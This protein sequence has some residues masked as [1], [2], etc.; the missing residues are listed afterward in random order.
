MQPAPALTTC[1]VNGLVGCFLITCTLSLLFYSPLRFHASVLGWPGTPVLHTLDLGGPRI[2]A[3]EKRETTD[4]STPS[5]LICV[6]ATLLLP[7]NARPRRAHD[8]AKIATSFFPQAS[9][10]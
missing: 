6:T 2:L 1:R 5:Q 7:R 9:R 4:S 10:E 8:A 3:G